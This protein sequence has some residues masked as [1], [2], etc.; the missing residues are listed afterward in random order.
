MQTQLFNKKAALRFF[1]NVNI[2]DKSTL[3]YFSWCLF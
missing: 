3:V 2:A 1:L